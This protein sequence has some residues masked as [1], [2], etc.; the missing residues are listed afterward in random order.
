MDKCLTV[1]DYGVKWVDVKDHY[2]TAKQEHRAITKFILNNPLPEYETFCELM[3]KRSTIK[4]IRFN[5]EETRDIY[6][7][8]YIPTKEEYHIIKML[9][10]NV[11][12]RETIKRIGEIIWERSGGWKQISDEYGTMYSGHKE[13]CKY[14]LWVCNQTPLML[15]GFTKSIAMNIECEWDGIGSWRK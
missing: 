6:G 1:A 14:Y 7:E 5:V 15:N 9:Y 4:R 13:M 3:K 8:N 10:D 12:S 11:L 2:N